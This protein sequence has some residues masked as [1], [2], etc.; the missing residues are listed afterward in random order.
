MKL[1]TFDDENAWG[2]MLHMAALQRGID[3]RLFRDP[4]EVESGIAFVHMHHSMGR[5]NRDKR[6][7]SKLHEQPEVVTIPNLR[8]AQFYDDKAL[9]AKFLSK[10]MP[11][12]FY[13]KNVKAAMRAAATIG[14]PFIS[15]TSE[16]AGSNN[17]RL[18]V[19]EDAAMAE[20][21]LVFGEGLPLEAGKSGE[22]RRQQGYLIWQKFCAGNGYDYRVICIGAQ[23]L[24]IRRHNR[25]DRPMASGS[26]RIEYVNDLTTDPEAAAV[27]EFADHVAL[28]ERFGFVGF[29]IIRDRDERK[30]RLMEVTVG[31]TL[32]AYFNCKFLRGECQSGAHF[33]N[34]L[35]DELDS[36]A[37]TP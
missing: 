37:L 9:Q 12:T 2:Q 4:R 11:P 5:R 33:F 30:W 35:L 3:A 16:G 21:I 13:C 27:L 26:G 24:M 25:D 15:K 20:A 28:V 19:S 14:Y 8:S 34:V 6:M 32:P 23:R 1:F 22:D 17:V 31:W 18:I 10:W 7:I 29:D 36:G